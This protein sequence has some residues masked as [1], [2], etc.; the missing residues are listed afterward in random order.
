MDDHYLKGVA[1]VN[2]KEYEQAFK[3]KVKVK[4]LRYSWDD[5]TYKWDKYREDIHKQSGMWGSKGNGV[6]I[7]FNYAVCYKTTYQVKDS[8]KEE[9]VDKHTYLKL[10][11]SQ[12]NSN[13][14][15]HMR[16]ELP[17]TQEREDFMENLSKSLHT[18]AKQGT[19][20]FRE[21]DDFQDRLDG[22]IF[23]GSN[24]LPAPKEEN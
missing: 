14:D 13:T 8:W 21:T 11:G 10:D 6:E 15:G 4:V 17:W 22:F 18:L 7:S 23:D 12:Y 19:E 16:Q 20:F 5:K 2:L 9:L 1:L 3:T 24:F